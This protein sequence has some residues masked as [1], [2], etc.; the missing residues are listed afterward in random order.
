MTIGWGEQRRFE[1]S[2]TAF[3]CHLVLRDE[4]EISARGFAQTAKEKHMAICKQTTACTIAVASAVAF[5]AIPTS[6]QAISVPWTVGKEAIP[7]ATSYIR[8]YRGY[9]SPFHRNNDAGVGFD[10]CTNVRESIAIGG[11]ADVTQSRR[12]RRERP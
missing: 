3:R 12:N 4:R 9:R 6:S 7:I 2:F 1:G 5:G 10:A 8:H 11:K